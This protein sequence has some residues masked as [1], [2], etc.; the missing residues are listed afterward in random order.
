MH[1]G[2]FVSGARFGVGFR[3]AVGQ[4][5]RVATSLPGDPKRGSSSH[6]EGPSGESTNRQRVAN[7]KA[8]PEL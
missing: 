4:C 3:T 7:P 1:L 2:P 6:D 5:D 8:T